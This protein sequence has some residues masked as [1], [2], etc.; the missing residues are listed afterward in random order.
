MQD[1][2][3]PQTPIPFMD[4]L[5]N[6]AGDGGYFRQIG[7]AHHALYRPAGKTLLV[8][9]D[10]L[11]AV[12]TR[13][14]AQ[15]WSSRLAR[16]RGWSTL[17]I[18]SNG[19]TWFR[20]KALFAYFDGLTDDEF[21]DDFERVVFAGA[22][23]GAYAAAAYSVAAP[24]ATVFLVRPFATLDR[25]IAPWERRF[26]SDWSLSFGPRYG[27]APGMLDAAERVYVVSDPTE[28]TDAMHASLFRGD[29]ITHLPARN[30]GQDLRT[31]LEAMGIL[32][33]IVAGAEAGSLTPL[34]FAQ[35]WRARH[36]DAV[37]LSGMLRKIDGMQRPW[38]Q[39]V[40]ASEMLRRTGSPAARRRLNAALAQ[41]DADGKT[42]PH[43]L[44]PS[45]PTVRDRM[46]MAGE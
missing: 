4:H 21:F 1:A 40:F 19:R 24:G 6:L 32:D 15:P 20:D 36:Q 29:H 35:L 14:G 10:I 2:P 44:G 22:D 42:P 38:L 31:R 8:E 5:S 33:R 16:K 23:T 28:R 27:Y 43:G 37:W 18:L 13:P 25:T 45:V 41:L 17:S 11:G 12:R 30:G 34:R 7:E 26:R 9:F 3:D 46:L 39:A